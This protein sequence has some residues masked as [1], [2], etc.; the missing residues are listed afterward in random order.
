VIGVG[1]VPEL[2]LRRQATLDFW[3]PGEEIAGGPA[4]KPAPAAMMAD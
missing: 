4:G 2:S 1:I 3:Q